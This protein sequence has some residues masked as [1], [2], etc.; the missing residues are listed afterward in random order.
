M[1]IKK[2]GRKRRETSRKNVRTTRFSPFFFCFTFFTSAQRKIG[3][4]YEI[5]ARVCDK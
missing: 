1:G 3:R 4:V 2:R 5:C